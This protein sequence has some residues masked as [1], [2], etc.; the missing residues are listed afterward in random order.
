M[1]NQSVGD[2]RLSPLAERNRKKRAKMSSKK[3]SLSASVIRKKRGNVVSAQLNKMGQLGNFPSIKPRHH[4]QHHPASNRLH[5]LGSMPLTI[6]IS[7][8]IGIG[9]G[10]G[11]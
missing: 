3:R 9:I 1:A 5:G 4:T 6:G 7:I 10:I 8:G 2:Q 11:R